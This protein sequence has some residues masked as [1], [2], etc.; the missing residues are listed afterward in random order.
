MTDVTPE[1]NPADEPTSNE[2][3]IQRLEDEIGKLRKYRE[4]ILGKSTDES[5]APS[6]TVTPAKTESTSVGSTPPL[7]EDVPHPVD[8]NGAPDMK[9]PGAHQNPVSYAHLSN[10]D[11][12]KIAGAI[13]TWIHTAE[14]ELVKVISAHPMLMKNG[15]Q[16]LAG[17][18][19]S[20]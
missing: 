16:M 13:P 20:L 1:T 15:M 9:E 14:G 6:E 10:G 8:A 17:L 12:V 5:S 18:L 2:T 19:K 11:V 4:G 7:L 3:Y